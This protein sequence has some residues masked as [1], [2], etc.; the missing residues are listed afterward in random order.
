VPAIADQTVLTWGLG[1]GVGDALTYRNDRGETVR[2]RFVGGLA[3]S[4]F[5]GNVIISEEAFRTHFPTIAGSRFFLVDVPQ[6][7]QEELS[8]SLR[9]RL[10]TYGLT[11][12]PAADRLAA[13]TVVQ[14]TYLVVFL[15]LGGLGVALGTLGL[16]AVLLRNVLETRPHLALLRAVG[17]PRGTVG[18]LVVTEHLFLLAAGLVLGVGSASA[19]TL[20]RLLVPGYTIPL[21]LLGL[22]VA[23]IGAGGLLGIVIAA[24]AALRGDLLPAL[25]RE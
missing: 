23:L 20:P 24:A 1:I 19:A 21:G 3:D 9:R 13:F 6:S 4:I 22:V 10:R 7:A 2:L 11:M 5:Q 25:R 17:F 18:R 12:T 8:E 16:A 14:N 15:I